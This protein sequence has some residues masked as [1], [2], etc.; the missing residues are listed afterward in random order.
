MVG[1]QRQVAAEAGSL[2]VVVGEIEI[3]AQ[4]LE[5]RGAREGPECECVSAGR[6]RLAV[7]DDLAW[8]HQGDAVGDPECAVEQFD[9][10]ELQLVRFLVQCRVLDEF[11]DQVARVRD[12][13]TP[14]LPTCRGRE[15]VE[16]ARLSHPLAPLKD[17]RPPDGPADDP[18]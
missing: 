17:A 5:P 7:I 12:P 6:G 15:I 1:T 18:L 4:I 3:A 9:G 16:G 10:V 14:Q 2:E 8:S 11:V 13:V